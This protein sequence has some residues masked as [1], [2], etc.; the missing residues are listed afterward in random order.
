MVSKIIRYETSSPAESVLIASDSDDQYSFEAASAQLKSLIPASIRVEE[1]RR[2]QLDDLTAK[3]KMIEA[4]NRGQKIV[5]YI[6][7]GSVDTWRG[8]MLTSADIV[9]LNNEDRLALFVMMTC[10]SGYFQDATLD[11]LAES[12]LKAE[13]G[14]A[15]AVWASSGM[16][17][18][19]GQTVINRELYRLVFAPAGQSLRLGEATRRAKAAIGDSDISRS[20][21]L[22]GDPTMRLK[23]TAAQ[24]I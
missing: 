12:L 22:F 23:L 4:I 1:V 18:L 9:K 15:V 20:W 17:V 16:T 10:L 2:G 6:G 11:S 13:R 3:S 5:N 24:M 19:E 7:H 14:G 8:G 21:I